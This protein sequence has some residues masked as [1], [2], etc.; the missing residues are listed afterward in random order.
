[1][2]RL[3]FTIF[4]LC[5]TWTL[6]AQTKTL[7]IKQQQ[8]DF[9]IFK[10][11]LNE[12]H[13]G[14]YYYIDK[15]SFERECDS[16]QK[17]FKDGSTV[18]NYYLKLRY[19]IT[20]LHHGHARISLPTSGNVNY[21]M[22]VLD[23]TKLYLPFQ[24]LIQKDKLIVIEDC[25]KEQ[26]IPKYAVVTSINNVSS[27]DLINKMLPYLPADGINQT[28]KNYSLYNYFYFHYLFNLFYPQKKGVKVEFED[29]K[30][31]FYIQLI[32]P[33]NIDSIYFAKNKKSISEFG[34][35]LAYKSNLTEEIA[36]LRVTSFYKGLIENF[37]Q[38]YETFLDSCFADIKQKGKS[39]LIIDLRNNEGGG[40]NY[41][42][43]LF[44]YL[45]EEPFTS[46][47]DVKVAGRTFK[48][49][50]YAS[51]SSDG[52]K[53]FL[54]N[55]NEFLRNDTSLFLKKEYAEEMD[56]APNKNLFVGDIYVL[57]NGGTFSAAT[58]LVRLLYNRRM[59]SP[60][61]IRFIGEEQGGDIYSQVECSGQSYIIEL[62][63]S[64]IK[65]DMPALCGGQ[66]NKTYP[67]KRLPDFEV[68]ESV[69][70]LTANKDDILQFTIDNI[71]KISKPLV[72]SVKINKR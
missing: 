56:F 35:Q 9:D 30:T 11:G 71:E 14:L 36:Y 48:Y 70:S 42:N 44:S 22:A 16:I 60:R 18:E 55:P 68:Y 59:K 51:N 1:M 21:K 12:G 52:L 6:Q 33:K 54:E 45:N 41:E 64:R 72:K 17:T 62:P 46:N 53:M 15:Q 50:Q 37:K 25:S 20:S 7:T 19:I 43:L 2:H 4:T 34:K 65:V 66:L 29:N 23:T 10:G 39:K 58:N 27:K 26:L 24:F 32:R 67:K 3:L 40:D 61:I 57:T 8:E 13:S 63:N 69:K 31:H 49:K 5:S 38:S 47:Q 28:Y